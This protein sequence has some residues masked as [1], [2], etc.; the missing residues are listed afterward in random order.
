MNNNVIQLNS[1]PDN[2]GRSIRTGEGIPVVLRLIGCE[3]ITSTKWG[4][5]YK[6]KWGEFAPVRG[7]GLTLVKQPTKW[8]LYF[9]L[10]F[11]MVFLTKHRPFVTEKQIKEPE[12]EYG[13]RYFDRAI[14]LP[15]GTEGRIIQMPWAFVWSW[16]AI[17]NKELE[18]VYVNTKAVGVYVQS[19]DARQIE[20]HAKQQVKMIYP[21]SY[22]LSNGMIQR[23]HAHTYIFRTSW[24]WNWWKW[25]TITKQ[26]INVSFNAPIG[27]K[28]VAGT[29]YEMIPGETMEN[30]VRRM[31]K[32]MK[33]D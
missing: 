1:P 4:S 20:D 17:L 27:E 8:Q 19:T 12:K 32:E 6:F 24:R 11:C 23:R 2:E 7:I 33:F 18:V 21:Y 26:Y 25:K 31:E 29:N 13:I 5:T 3:V 28:E 9:G 10:I 30:A 15:W 16:T 14:Q 22:V